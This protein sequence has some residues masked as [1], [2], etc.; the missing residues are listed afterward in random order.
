MKLKELFRRLNIRPKNIKIYE[1]ALT[2]SS[3]ANENNLKK[4]NNERLEF[5]GD[6]V[7][8]FLMASYLYKKNQDNEGIMTK[9]RAQ[10]VCIESLLIYAKEIE[11]KKYILLGKG[12]RKRYNKNHSIVSDA[13][14]ALFGAIYL[15]LGYEQ[16]KK[17]FIYIVL[18]CLKKTINII[19]FKTQLQELIQT[20]KKNI[21]YKIISEKGLAHEKE[22]VAEVY[23]ENKLLGRG[24]GKT[25][26]ASEQ[27]AAEKALI[28]IN[29][30]RLM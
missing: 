28:K 16:V 30:E 24:I 15:D 21:S 8:N 27:K 10:A 19:D 4:N 9:K 17:T 23:L 25:K 5:L 11:L 7:I 29:K 1:K 12:E 3:Y 20:S 26:K 13:F 18:P 14:E 6:A 2:H 22:F